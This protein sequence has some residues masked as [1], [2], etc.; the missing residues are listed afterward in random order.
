MLCVALIGATA[1]TA[2]RLYGPACGLAALGLGLI[3]PF[4]LFQ[5][6]SYLSHPIAGGILACAI[7]AFVA[8]ERSGSRRWYAVCGALFGVAFLVREVAAVLV[9][10]PL[11]VRLLACRRWSALGAVV[12][13]G[14]PFVA[15]YLAYNWLQTGS[16]LLLPRVIFNPGDHFGFGDGVGFYMRH[17]LAAGLANTD[18]L[19]TLLQ[20]DLFG[21]P[22]LFAFGLILVPF[23]VGRAHTWDFVALGGVLA[24]VI[25]YVGYF[26]HGVALG[27]RYYFEAMP[28]LLLLAARG[29]QV[30][31]GLAASRLVPLA[32]LGVL[33]LNTVMFYTQAELERRTDMSGVSGV[34]SVNLGFVQSSLLGPRIVGVPGNSLVVTNEWWLYNTALAALNCPQLPQ[35]DVLFAF[36]QNP[37][38]MCDRFAGEYPGRVLLRA[39]D[40]VARVQDPGTSRTRRTEPARAQ[41]D[42]LA[43]HVGAGIVHAG[44]AA[45]S[46]FTGPAPMTQR[47][48][49]RVGA[50]EGCAIGLA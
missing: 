11:G 5:A 6:D 13:L 47:P 25:A 41:S 42:R 27:P 16:P 36:A 1:W 28:W 10:L 12:A 23:L 14:V 8:G 3:S 19:L 9:A 32:L 50:P 48:A 38:R 49:A 17:T 15:L 18:E 33:T 44:L 29:A 40:L 21:W 39:I 20:F 34:R 46:G 24:F 43:T 26:Y 7:A 4:I 31:A 2:G 22:P 37:C 30:L 35:C 45:A